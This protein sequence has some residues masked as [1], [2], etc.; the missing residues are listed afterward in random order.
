MIAGT[1]LLAGLVA[2]GPRVTVGPGTWRPVYPPSPGEEAVPVDAFALDV[3]PV[4]VADFERFVGAHP[5]W[6]RGAA[7][8]ALVDAGYLARWA[9]DDASG[10][11]ERRAPVTEVSWFAAR[12]Y[13][14]AEG[15]RLPTEA[16][17]ELAA[18]ADETRLDAS[19]DPVFVQ[20]ILDWYGAA[21]PKQLPAVGLGRANAWG[22]HD[23]HGLAWE[24]VDD[25]NASLVNVDNRDGKGADDL[26][27][28]GGGAAAAAGD[29]ADYA[30][31][32]RVALR[33][34]LE[35]NSTLRSLGFRCAYEVHA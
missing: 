1:L 30:A 3:Y 21:N 12:A 14:R 29:K 17:W 4:R 10:A 32:M 6:Q 9:T 31:F 11:T 23:L 8:R 18:S 15:G 2:A 7:S 22:V 19:R 20:R 28:C 27:F 26:R 33:S 13:C 25:F 5:E 16:E 24:W 34:S 35:G